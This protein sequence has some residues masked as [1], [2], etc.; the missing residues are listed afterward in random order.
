MLNDY[1]LAEV[2]CMEIVKAQ[3]DDTVEVLELVREVIK[4]MNAN[5]IYQWSD[6]YPPR[7]IFKSDIESG[8]LFAMMDNVH[9]VGIIV[10]SEYQ[11]EEYEQ[12]DWTDKSGKALIV[13]R[14]AVH[15]IWQRMG[16]AD[17]LMDYAEIYAMENEYSSIRV[18]T[19][20]GNQR[21]LNFFEKRK[22]D[23]KPGHIHFPEI[24]GPFYCYEILITNEDKT[25]G[26]RN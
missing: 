1:D 10:L 13:H 14:L 8:T 4:D 9:I 26:I 7:E 6:K 25:K 17:M 23:K 20:S 12:V 16:I 3:P 18:D 19:Y 22:Y 15:P 21:S 11:D 5:G 24:E 2:N